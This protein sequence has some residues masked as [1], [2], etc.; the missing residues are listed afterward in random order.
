MIKAY[1]VALTATC[2]MV[3]GAN[4]QTKTTQLIIAGTNGQIKLNPPGSPGSGTRAYNF[5]NAPNGAS[6]IL[7]ESTAGKT[8]D[9]PLTLTGPV[10]F[11]DQ[12]SLTLGGS[13]G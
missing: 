8:I 7:S 13:S 3:L 11:G 12:L 1:V 6:I 9:G 2:L 10:T 4:A 5:P